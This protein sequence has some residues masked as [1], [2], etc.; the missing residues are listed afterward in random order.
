M[1][2]EE[3]EKDIPPTPS[4]P[5]TIPSNVNTTQRSHWSLLTQEWLKILY[6]TTE[7]I[8]TLENYN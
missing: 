1:G 5:T 7:I 2:K 3:R 4:H 8:K 6:N